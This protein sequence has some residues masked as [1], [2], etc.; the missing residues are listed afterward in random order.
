MAELSQNLIARRD[1][2]A[3]AEALGEL[4]VDPPERDQRQEAREHDEVGPL[5]THLVLGPH[6]VGRD[7]VGDDRQRGGAEL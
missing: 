2:V 3:P 5:G 1:V 7:E 4:S 6:G